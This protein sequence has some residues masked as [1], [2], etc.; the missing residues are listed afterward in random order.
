M[1]QQN[2]D[3]AKYLLGQTIIFV[4]V[5]KMGPFPSAVALAVVFF[6]GQSEK[7]L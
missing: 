6:P 3:L 7:A 2:G 1:N 4:L 5:E